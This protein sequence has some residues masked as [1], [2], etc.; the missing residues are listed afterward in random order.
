MARAL[1][2][3][4]RHR[5]VF[6]NGSGTCTGMASGLSLMTS[7]KPEGGGMGF[8]VFGH[9]FDVQRE[10]LLCPVERLIEGGCGG[11][12]A[13]KGGERH[14][15][16]FNPPWPTYRVIQMGASMREANS[17]VVWNFN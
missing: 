12:G 17:W 1:M 6:A 15:S 9:A 10:R 8:D 11:N 7:A 4:C 14:D 16:F 2:D 5:T 3:R 13:G